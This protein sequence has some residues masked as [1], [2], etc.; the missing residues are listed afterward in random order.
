[1]ARTEPEANDTPRQQK[2]AAKR[3]RILDAAERLFARHG[4][5]KTTVDEIAVAAAVSKGL[6]YLHFSAKEALLEA[7]LD[8]ELAE[9][10]R[11]T[12]RTVGE[13][14]G[15]IVECVANSLRGSI[16]HARNNPLLRGILAQD[17]R[18]F[19]PR[20]E[21]AKGSRKSVMAEYV[22]LLEP[23]LVR[24][25]ERGE[26]RGDLDVARTAHTIWLLHDSLVRTLFVEG[27][28]EDAAEGDALVEAAIS[29]MS[30]G[31]RTTAK[32]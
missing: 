12:A 16:A 5:A 7:V 30:T 11:A 8:R 14:G 20:R 29:L 1:M 21:D 6:I 24:G 28:I 18:L 31:I 9:W 17:P 27:R 26:L 19:L 13:A 15:D 10:G 23:L 4:Y 22:A 3:N 25:I 2:T 32:D